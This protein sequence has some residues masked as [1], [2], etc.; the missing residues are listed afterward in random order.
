[1]QKHLLKALPL[2]AAILG[3]KYG[4]QVIIGGDT[5]ATNG[6]KIYLPSLPLDSPPELLNLVRGYIDHEAAHLRATDFKAFKEAK[7]SPI[8]KHIWNCLEDWRVEEILGKIFPGCRK[9]F[10]WLILHLFNKKRK[11]TVDAG[12]N[13]LNWFLYTV[14][15]WAVPELNT[16]LK[17]IEQ[18]VEADF[19]KLLQ[20]LNPLMDK[21]RKFCPDTKAAIN[22]ARALAQCLKDISTSEDYSNN[23]ASQNALQNIIE[24][25]EQSLPQ[26]FDG[27]LEDLLNEGKGKNKSKCLQ[28][29]Q[30]QILK[31]NALTDKDVA[32]A[33]SSTLALKSRLQNLLQSQ[34]VKRFSS[35]RRGKLDSTG[36]YKISIDNPKVFRSAGKR[37]GLN[38]AVHLLI[39][40]SG[41]MSLQMNF[42]CLI[43]YALVKSLAETPGINVGASVF[44]V[45]P[46]LNGQI[47]QSWNSVATVLDHGQKVHQ[48]F[49]LT[50]NGGTPLGEALWW[51]LGEMLV[52][53]ESRKII[54]ILTDG[55]PDSV[56]N[57]KAAIACTKRL[58]F[59]LYG[60]GIGNTVIAE[61]LPEQSVVINKLS[62]LAPKLF[63]LLQKALLKSR[64]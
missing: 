20:K 31:T 43:A 37:V 46:I 13:I 24:G 21:I 47:Q 17:S 58:G 10:R 8:E 29:A 50:A 59:E 16:R 36:L 48:N 30:K 60:L 54:L 33:R 53:P 62:E 32:A 2:V 18:Q 15:A 23:N 39:D 4:L 19:P 49:K 25:G 5:A 14:R 38:T 45:G 64:P 3:R 1:M 63:R 57:T 40:A 44:P 42:V 61:L 28:V 6:Q 41:S 56:E 22:Y 35:G 7:L 27:L 11:K 51:L 52:L 34:T 12:A 9:N 55:D 26:T